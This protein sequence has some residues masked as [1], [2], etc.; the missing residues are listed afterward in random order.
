M[1]KTAPGK[2]LTNKIT[3]ISFA[4]VCFLLLPFVSLSQYV[5]THIKQALIND[6]LK[7]YSG[8]IK[9]YDQAIQLDPGFAKAYYLR[10]KAEY[11][12]Q[13]YNGAI[14]DENTA[15]RLQLK[16]ENVY[17]ISAY[18]RMALKQYKA[19]IADFDKA[20]GFNKENSIT[21]Y[22]RGFAKARLNYKNARF[23]FS[24][25]IKLGNKESGDLETE[26]E[27]E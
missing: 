6:S 24:K 23:D 9:E 22:H 20:I 27:P 19:A 10:G 1:K 3:S 4:A 18:A 7:N 25:A 26:F 11:C 21:Y 13:D 5:N 12:L 17:L 14:K 15:A 2:Q 8:A 16:N